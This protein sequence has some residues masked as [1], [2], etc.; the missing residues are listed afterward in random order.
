MEEAGSRAAV[1]GRLLVMGWGKASGWAAGMAELPGRRQNRKARLLPAV[2]KPHALVKVRLQARRLNRP[3]MLTG[4]RQNRLGKLQALVRVKLQV[5]HQ[6]MRVLQP[7][8]TGWNRMVRLQALVRVMLQ[9]K[10]Q[11]RT[12]M[13]L[14]LGRWKLQPDSWNRLAKLQA[15]AMVRL[16]VR[17]LS[18]MGKLPGQMEKLRSVVQLLAMRLERA[19]MVLQ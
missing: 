2:V 17:L 19:M 10:R 15:L 8:G 1:E 13:P 3:A 16:W 9:V 12:V 18:R 14:A 5:R 11:N 6:N 4:R 7:T